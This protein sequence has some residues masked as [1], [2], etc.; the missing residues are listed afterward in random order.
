MEQSITFMGE[1]DFLNDWDQWKNTL[2]RAIKL[3]PKIG[4]SDN[5]IEID[6]AKASGFFAKILG[7]ESKEEALI[8]GLWS[9]ATFPEKKTLG[10]L[11][12]KLM[13]K[14]ANEYSNQEQDEPYGGY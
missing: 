8:K 7:V 14:S 6:T 11:L 4:L 2:N 10:E 13:D 12:F 1:L 3:T 9:V 5:L